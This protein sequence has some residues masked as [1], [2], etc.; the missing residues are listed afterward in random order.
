MMKSEI[1]WIFLR[2][3]H[4]VLL[5][6]KFILF[7]FHVKCGFLGNFFNNLEQIIS[8]IKKIFLGGKDA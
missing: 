5:I 8:L 4:L 7:Q 2:A 1:F 3:F 6:K